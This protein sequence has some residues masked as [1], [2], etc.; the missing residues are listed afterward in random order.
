M[1]ARNQKGKNL[2]S[3]SSQVLY[4]SCFMWPQ[5]YQNSQNT[6]IIAQL[7]KELYLRRC[8]LSVTKGKCVESCK[9]K[10]SD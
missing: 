4:H 8:Y 7:K 5:K 3:Q 9:E 6:E 2:I 1:T 10:R